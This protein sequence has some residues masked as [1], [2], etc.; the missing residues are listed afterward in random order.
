MEDKIKHLAE[1]NFNISLKPEQLKAI[2]SYADGRHTLLIAPTSYGKSIVYQMAPFIYD[3]DR[4][5]NDSIIS[6]TN[7]TTVLETSARQ[8]SP[9]R[10]WASSDEELSTSSTGSLAHAAPDTSTPLRPEETENAAPPDTGITKPTTEQQPADDFVADL[11]SNMSG[12]SINVSRLQ[13]E[14]PEIPLSNTVK[15]SVRVGPSSFMHI[16]YDDDHH[17]MINL[18]DDNILAFLCRLLIIGQ[19][20]S[21]S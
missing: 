18:Y 6:T 2:N 12:L 16:Y 15:V 10:Q 14:T 7:T 1:A 13:L 17:H 5:N 19:R 8:S 9:D 21:K 3:D 4:Y 11:S 20:F